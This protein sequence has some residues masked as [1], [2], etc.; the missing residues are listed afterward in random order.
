MLTSDS[1]SNVHTLEKVAM[2]KAVYSCTA[3]FGWHGRLNIKY[4][5]MF[6]LPKKDENLY[7]PPGL[8]QE[9]D[10]KLYKSG[11]RIRLFRC[12]GQ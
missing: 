12:F 9:D 5:C 2:F 11:G 1:E 7:E 8:R 6:K 4:L 10:K 3:S